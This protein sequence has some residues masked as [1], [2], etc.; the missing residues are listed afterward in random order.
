MMHLMD[1][2]KV[3]EGLLELMETEGLDVQLSYDGLRVQLSY[4]S[5]LQNRYP[6]QSAKHL[7]IQESDSQLKDLCKW[8]RPTTMG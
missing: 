5:L 6:L 7:V 4:D 8:T 1:H 2:E 3:N